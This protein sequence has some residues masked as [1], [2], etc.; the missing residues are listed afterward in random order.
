MFVIYAWDLEI[1]SGINSNIRI[2]GVWASAYAKDLVWSLHS[3]VA[4]IFVSKQALKL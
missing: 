3:E 1:S 4:E 2:F